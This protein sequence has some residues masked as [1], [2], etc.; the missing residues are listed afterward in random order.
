MISL[1]IIVPVFHA[2]QF[3]DKCVQSLLNQ[4]LTDREYEIILVDDGSS[5]DNCPV[6][7]DHYAEQYP[8]IRVIHQENKGLSEARNAGIREA[9]GQYITFVDADDYVETDSYKAVLLQASTN[10]LDILQFRVQIVRKDKI[11][12]IEESVE[13]H[14]V[15]TGEQFVEKCMGVKCYAVRY[16][17]RRTLLTGNAVF[18]HKGIHYEDVEWLPRVLYAAQRVMQS[19]DIIYNYVI[20]ENTITHPT[21]KEKWERLIQD[22]LYVLSRYVDLIAVKKESLWLLA[23]SANIITSALT[24]V[25]KQFY[26]DRE[27]YIGQIRTIYPYPLVSKRNFP[28]AERLKVTVARISL[29]LYCFIRHYI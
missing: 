20:R 22:N 3:L 14:V 13:E 19:D 10:N 4:D 6:M 26:R 2:E 27:M 9:K 7:C 21:T 5:D 11:I 15:Y 17:I 29:E 1:S 16:L 25:A 18:F 28:F 12:P 24:I 23:M 8:Q